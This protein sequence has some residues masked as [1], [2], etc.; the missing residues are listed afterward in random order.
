[1]ARD[2]HLA[3]EPTPDVTRVELGPED[4]DQQIRTVR[5]EQRLAGIAVMLLDTTKI[6]EPVVELLC[7]RALRW[8]ALLSTV[9]LTALALRDPSWER[10]AI[11]AA[12]AILAP[13]IIRKGRT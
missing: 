5:R 11:V 6:L 4:L 13:W 7:D 12:F 3:G 8:V 9:W 10:G 1:M 2:L